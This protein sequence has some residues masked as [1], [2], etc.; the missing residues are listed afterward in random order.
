MKLAFL[1]FLTLLFPLLSITAAAAFYIYHGDVTQLEQRIQERERNLHQSALHITRLHFAPIIDDLRYLTQKA[2]ELSINSHTTA[3]QKDILA[4]T[5][6]RMTQTRAYYDQIRLINAQGLEVIRINMKDGQAYRIPEKQLQDKSHRPYVQESLQISPDTFY[7]SQFDLNMEN[8]QIETPIKPML[9]FIS[10]FIINGESWLISLN[11][12]GRDYLAELDNQYN[13]SDG[14]NWLVNNKGN[15][16]LGPTSDSAWQFMP[17]RQNT[18]G[19]DFFQTHPALWGQIKFSESGQVLQGEYLYTFTRFFSGDKFL[20][21]E[22]FTLPFDGTDLPWTIISRI[23]MSEA[24]FELAF[25]QQ[26]IV[27]FAIFT[28]LIMTLVSGCIV[29]A[30]HLLH[31]LRHEKSLKQ[32]I[33]DV[34]LKYSTVLEHAPDGLIT[35]SLDMTI[36][37]INK[38]AGHILNINVQSAKGK[39]LLKLINGHKNRE[40]MKQLVDEVRENKAKDNHHPVKTRI[41]LSS[42]KTRH[43]EFI[44]T[45]TTYSSSSELLLNFRDVTYWIE[46]EEKLKS[47]SRALEQSNDSIVITNHRGIIEYVNQAFEKFTGVRSKDIIGAQ[48]STLLKRTLDDEK[49]VRKVQEQLKNGQT[50]HRVLARRQ[51]DDSILYEEKTISPIRNNRGKISHYISMGK[52]ITERVLFESK[53]HKLAHYDLLTELPNRTLLQQFLEKAIEAAKQDLSSI[54]LLTIDLD[55]FKKINDSLS[56][57]TGDKVLLAISK[58]INSS[59]REDDL[60]ARLGGDEFAIIIKQGVEPENIVNMANRIIK[61]ISEPLCI[62]NKELFITASMGISLF[63]DDSYDIETLLKNADIA[64]YR[65]KEEGR[66]KFCF[67]TQ[68]MGLDSIKRIQ[69]ESELRKSIGT[70]RYQFY[71]QPKVNAITHDICG[72]EA[73]LRWEDENGQIQPPLDIIPILEHSGLIIE[74]GEYLI[75]R[76]CRQLKKWQQENHLLHFALNI[77]ARQL[78]YSNIVETVSKAI[79][80]TGCDPQ[81]LELEITESVIMAD[82]KTAL[83]KLM[84]LEALG[85]KIAIDDFGT[86]YSSLAY[87]SR[88]PVHIL[89]VDREFVKDLPKNKDNIT[90]TRSIVELAHNLDMVVV[91]EGVETEAQEQFLASIGVE[92]FQGFYFG[93]PMPLEEFERQYLTA[94]DIHLISEHFCKDI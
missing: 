44:A 60:L 30:W 7:T 6:K 2:N 85:V 16:L 56:H 91:A 17:S 65:A 58:R 26:R 5:F 55:H 86:G 41:Q 88:F 25:S 46:R 48:S 57:D 12:Q 79:E 4:N 76:A 74:A 68:Q 66:N 18:Q 45:E 61:H 8:G 49:D 34:A 93:A 22:L 32:D 63:P 33:E 13:W 9:R 78:L 64:L 53:L 36:N 92:E 20:G 50:I 54:A 73:L 10:H 87:L 89:K 51:N 35:I 11:Y 21:D 52:D 71:Y 29:L 28:L 70:Q 83:N 14:Q 3:Q 39:N 77:S 90:I 15:W 37:T 62:D 69:L 75:Q 43:I 27:K 38:A 19:Q 72:I 40:Q 59:L 47:M 42:L 82:V 24:V 81:Y 94:P 84:G 67:F 23:N 1:R 31:M 80:E